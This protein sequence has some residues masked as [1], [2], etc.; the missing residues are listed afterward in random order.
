MRPT[1]ILAK[2]IP[3]RGSWVEFE[4]DQKNILYVRIDRK[5]SSRDD[6]FAPLSH[7]D[8]I[9]FTL[10]IIVTVVGRQAALQTLD[11]SVVPRLTR[12]QRSKD[13]A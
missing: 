3:Y 12:Y 10:F 6:I 7:S 1:F 4:F 11:G 2:I 8:S 13:E 5:E 9:Y